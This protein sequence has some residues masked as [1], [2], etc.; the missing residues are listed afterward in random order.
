[1]TPEIVFTTLY[2]FVAYE[3]DQEVSVALQYTLK[4]CQ[5]KTLAYLAHQKATKNMKCCEYD[6]K[7]CYIHNT[8]A[9]EWAQ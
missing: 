8:Y 1:M 3:W 6:S 2:F 5:G 7:D 4:A 9:Y